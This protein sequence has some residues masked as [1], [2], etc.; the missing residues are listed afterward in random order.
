MFFKIFG[1]SLA[2]LI[3]SDDAFAQAAAPAPGGASSL[4]P[5][6]LI[7]VIFYFFIIRPQSK[8]LKEHAQMV[9][10]LKRGDRVVTGGGIEGVISK[11]GDDGKL[12]VEIAK[13]VKVKVIANS[14]TDLVS[15]TSS[16]EKPKEVNNKKNNKNNKKA[17]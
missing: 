2:T 1:Y 14:V 6:V 12:E 13:D 15:R 16:V 5:L 8:K 4:I 3:F 9:A 7:F 17:A 11:V 10:S